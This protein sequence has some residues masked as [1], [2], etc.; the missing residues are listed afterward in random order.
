[1]KIEKVILNSLYKNDYENL[2][3]NKSINQENTQSNSSNNRLWSIS[4]NDNYIGNIK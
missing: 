2:F 4:F 3:M 1:M